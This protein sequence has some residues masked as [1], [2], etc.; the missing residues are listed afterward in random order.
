M[1]RS[2]LRYSHN[3]M[4]FQKKKKQLNR[5]YA[6]TLTKKAKYLNCVSRRF[7]HLFLILI[8]IWFLEDS[9]WEG[10]WIPL[11][12]VSVQVCYLPFPC[13][14]ESIQEMKNP[15]QL[16]DGTEKG[17]WVRTSECILGSQMKI[18]ILTDKCILR[19]FSIEI[20]DTLGWKEWYKHSLSINVY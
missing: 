18:L 11:A 16:S 15:P 12:E 13:R 7:Y 5:K 2:L 4:K 10:Q 9:T 20:V 19:T 17:N 1:K 8:R 6:R 3:F 14:Y